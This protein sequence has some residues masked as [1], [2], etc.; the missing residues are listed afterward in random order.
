MAFVPDEAGFRAREVSGSAFKAYVYFC[1]RRDSKTGICWPSSRQMAADLHIAQRRAIS[2]RQELIEA[3]WIRIEEEKHGQTPIIRPLLGFGNGADKLSSPDDKAASPRDDKVTSPEMT[4]RHQKVMTKVTKGDD[5]SVMRINR[6]NQ[7][8]NQPIEESSSFSEQFQKEVST[9]ASSR[10]RG[11]TAQFSD[12][13]Q[14]ERCASAGN[15]ALATAA[16]RHSLADLEAYAASKKGIR[17]P[18]GLAHVLKRTGEDDAIVDL[19]LAHRCRTAR[20]A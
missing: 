8:M 18:A 19:F 3:G 6:L 20:S 7:P 12:P 15:L 4:K 11:G 13:E 16:S 9:R 17:N 14:S 10:A 2:A 1:I 5:K